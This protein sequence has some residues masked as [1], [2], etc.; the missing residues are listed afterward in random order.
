MVLS[1]ALM[2]KLTLLSNFYGNDD[3]ASGS[4]GVY[5]FFFVNILL[6]KIKK[7]RSNS[8]KNK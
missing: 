2:T 4:G 1:A 5:S 7:E 8:I 3:R 6:I